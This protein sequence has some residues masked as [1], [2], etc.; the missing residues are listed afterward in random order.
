LSQL[1]S[2][3]RQVRNADAQCVVRVPAVA[4]RSAI[5]VREAFDFG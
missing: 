2:V 4:M 1:K 3:A 5:R